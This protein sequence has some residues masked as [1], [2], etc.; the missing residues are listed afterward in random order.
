[1]YG[2]FLKISWRNLHRNKV[3]SAIKIGGF[4]L[5]I[6][7]CIL[8]AL[9]IKHETS[10]DKHYKNGDQ[11]FRISNEYSDAGYFGRWTNLQGPFKPVLEEHIPEIETVSRAVLWKWGNAGENHIRKIESVQNIYE[12][13][14]F[15]A[16]PEF[17]SILEIPMVFGD[18]KLALSSPNQ[19]VISKSKADKY[20][21]NENP[22]GRQM[23][24]NDN[25]NTAYTIG[26]VMEDFPLTSHLQGDFILTLTGRTTGP[27]SSGWCCSNYDFYVKL[28][29]GADKL[30]VEDKLVTMR[31]TYVLDQ[32]EAGTDEL[33]EIQNNQK[34]YLQPVQNIYLNQEEVGDH[35]AH[36]S[37]YAVW[38]FGAIA[39]V[40]LL[41]ASIN[42]IN[43]STAKSIKRAKEV[44]LRKVV[45]SF[46]INLIQQFLS[47]S[48]LYSILS[49]VLGIG[50]AYLMLPTFN[51]VADKSLI[52]PISTWWFAPLLILVAIVIGLISG[53]YPAFY[54]SHFKPISVLKGNL[55]SGKKGKS[56]RSGMVVFQFTAT[57][58]LITGALVTHQQFEH[59]MNKSIGYEKEQVVNILG[60][61]S[62]DSLERDLL[63]NQ[64]LNQSTVQAATLGDYL[65][66]AGSRITNFGFQIDGE[67]T[68]DP[69]FEAAR[70]IV[71]ED[72]LNTMGIKL[73]AGRN[74]NDDLLDENSIIINQSMADAFDISDAIGLQLVDMFDG[75]YQVIG[76]VEDFY[77]ES[78]TTDVRPLAMVKGKGIA[79]LSIKLS[80]DNLEA[81]ITAISAAWSSID[82]NQP[83]RYSFMD[84]RFE[85]MYTSLS[86]AKNTVSWPFRFYQLWW[87]V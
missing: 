22:V 38:V 80:T 30:A 75:R 76:V 34:Y 41:L 23:V 46:R 35:I 19:M 8:I 16:D 74:F 37:I 57:V 58:I 15:Y 3:F 66:V 12:E 2:H 47:E 24:L 78:L 45:G 33:E 31:D 63:K 27:G 60:L 82:P 18:Q 9:F 84:E 69:G 65:P 87:L 85:R 11:L 5:G 77:F 48:I 62:L 49:T 54:L 59:Y 73:A 39:A 70:W 36:G 55:T 29:P 68:L 25:S 50:I 72:F 32:L 20:F 40:I 14:F 53:L 26:G 13:G 10:Y 21:P 51:L 71:D 64:V 79:T 81:S 28:I 61:N 4:A 43:L 56:L 42:F 86:R 17:L 1:M 83:I 52:I 67:S 6:A 44:G 7:A